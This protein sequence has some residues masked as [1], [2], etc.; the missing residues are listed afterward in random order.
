MQEPLVGGRRPP[1]WLPRR[2]PPP[3]SDRY[4]QGAEQD[5][6]SS[7]TGHG[8]SRAALAA[9]GVT[10]QAAAHASRTDLGRSTAF[11]ATPDDDPQY[12]R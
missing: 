8:A 6:R 9:L 1:R 12:E 2:R 11:A 10:T 4:P 5:G 3:G 7:Q